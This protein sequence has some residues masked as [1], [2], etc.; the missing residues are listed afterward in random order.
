MTIWRYQTRYRYIWKSMI[1]IISLI[2]MRVK[3]CWSNLRRNIIFLL[4]NSLLCQN[5]NWRLKR[6]RQHWGYACPVRWTHFSTIV[7]YQSTWFSV[8]TLRNFQPSSTL[9]WVPFYL[10]KIIIFCW[11]H[12]F[13]II[14]KKRIWNLLTQWCLI[15]WVVIITLS[16][17]KTILILIHFTIFIQ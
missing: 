13:C 15:K 7:P 17:I 5:F 9:S 2:N 3:W 11:I 14:W 1:L 4:E 12:K 6:Q 8:Q 16:I 10:I